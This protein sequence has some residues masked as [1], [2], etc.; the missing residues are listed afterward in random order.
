MYLNILRLLVFVC[1]V[2][3]LSGYLVQVCQLDFESK[4]VFL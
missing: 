4:G 2:E 1:Y 3:I